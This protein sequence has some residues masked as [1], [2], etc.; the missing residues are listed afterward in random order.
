MGFLDTNYG[1]QAAIIANYLILLSRVL[2]P[3]LVFHEHAQSELGQKLVFL[4]Y[5]DN[6]TVTV[7]GH[8]KPI[9]SQ[10]KQSCLGTPLPYDFTSDGPIIDDVSHLDLQ[11]WAALKA[12]PM[13]W[14]KLQVLCCF[15]C[16][17]FGPL[18][19]IVTLYR[20]LPIVPMD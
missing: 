8:C 7:P 12:I 2:S 15:E 3:T 9:D 13:C 19:E 4:Y 20:N 11:T 6:C 14:V 16:L 10:L 5:R 18:L 1:R 17:Y